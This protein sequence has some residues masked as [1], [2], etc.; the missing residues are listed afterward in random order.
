MKFRHIWTDEA[1]DIVKQNWGKRDLQSIK[2]MVAKYCKD[3][4]RAMGRSTY[5]TPSAA[6]VVWQAHRIGLIDESEK[7]SMLQS[8]KLKPLDGKTRKRIIHRDGERCIVCYSREALRVDFILPVFMGGLDNDENLQTLCRGCRFI[9]GMNAL[10]C[11]N[12]DDMVGAIIEFSPTEDATIYPV[13]KG[14]HLAD[15]VLRLYERRLVSLAAAAESSDLVSSE[16][17]APVAAAQVD[18]SWQTAVANCTYDEW[19]AEKRAI[20]WGQ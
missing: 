12:L 3:R 17:P 13:V 18:D 14:G 5:E 16:E 11:H 10:D 19:L 15:V 8:L 9:K 1:V 6:G 2:R 7:E 20:F 4:A